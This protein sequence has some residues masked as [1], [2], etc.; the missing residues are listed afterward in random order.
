MV[1]LLSASSLLYGWD[2]NRLLL[3]SSLLPLLL[4]LPPSLAP[5]LGAGSRGRGLRRR[6]GD[7]IAFNTP[8]HGLGLCRG[9]TFPQAAPRGI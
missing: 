9:V 7:K 6:L 1:C 4:L 2:I 8:E 3:P 5:F